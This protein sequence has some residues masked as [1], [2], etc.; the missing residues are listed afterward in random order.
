MWLY[1]NIGLAGPDGN[2]V[3]KSVGPRETS[4]HV[5]DRQPCVKTVKLQQTAFFGRQLWRQ[6]SNMT[7]L[8]PRSHRQFQLKEYWDTFFTRRNVPFE[9]YGEY[10][11]LCHLLHKYV[12]QPNK[13]LVVGCGNSKLSEDL[14]DAGIHNISNIDI[15]EVYK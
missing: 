8:L 15:S 14:Y 5:A 4:S 11:D 12:K 7:S 1:I 3:A 9:W 13:L 2:P 6:F 10:L